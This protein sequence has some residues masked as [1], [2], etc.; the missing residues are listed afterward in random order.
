[1]D[2][3][4]G[5]TFTK[6]FE[7]DCLEYLVTG[8]TP[9]VEYSFKVSAVN[10][11]Q[12]GAT[13]DVSSFKSCVAPHNIKAPWLVETT[14]QSVELRWES[15]EDGGCP[16]LSFSVY[17]DL[18][19]GLYFT[20]NLDAIDVENEPYKFSHVFTFSQDLTGQT[21]RFKLLAANE[22]GQTFSDDYL[23]VVLA[24]VPSAPIQ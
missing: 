9:A 12:E 4:F 2:D 5:V 14:A 17:S 13:S 16:I 21:L 1:M 20:N 23:E 11:N 18:G 24:G 19:T 8:L 3:G 10:F 22:I 15:P 7:A 6:V